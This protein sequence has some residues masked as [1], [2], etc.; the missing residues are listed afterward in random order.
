MYSGTENLDARQIK[1]LPH[2]I[3]PLFLPRPSYRW[4]C[5]AD[6]RRCSCGYFLLTTRALALIMRGL[7]FESVKRNTK[8][9][10]DQSADL[11][12]QDSLSLFRGRISFPVAVAVALVTA[13]CTLMGVLGGAWIALMTKDHELKIRLVEIGIGILRAD[14]KDDVT[15][16]RRWAIDV[17]Q[18]NSG[19]NF[20]EEEINLLLHK[21]IHSVDRTYGSTDAY[22]D[23]FTRDEKETK[24]K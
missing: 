7:F 20:S 11:K 6:R 18:N 14:P 15:P 17:I 1:C 3:A 23:T 24:R 2:N 4:G 9:M 22:Y 21:P 13:I 8:A 5:R 10:T 12:E 16:A 19:V